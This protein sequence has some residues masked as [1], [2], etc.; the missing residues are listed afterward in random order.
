[1]PTNDQYVGPDSTSQCKVFDQAQ[2]AVGKPKTSH[3]VQTVAL[4]LN[5]RL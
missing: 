5:R 4:A 1:M 3:F 2:S